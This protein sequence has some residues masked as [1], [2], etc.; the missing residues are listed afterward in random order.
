[1]NRRTQSLAAALVVALLGCPA[2]AAVSGLTLHVSP[3]GSDAGDGSAAKPFATPARA[4]QEVRK[5]AAGGLKQPVTVLLGAGTYELAQPLTFTPADGGSEA[6]GVTYA[7]APSQ[8]AILSGGRRIAGWKDVGGGLWQAQ[9]PGVKEGKWHF[10]QLW[11]NG[12][13]AVR[14]RTPNADTMLPPPPSAC[15]QLKDASLAG[16]LSSH[17]YTFPPGLLKE[18]K[19]LSDVEAVVLGNWETTRKRFDKVDPAAGVAQMAGPHAKPHDAIAAKPGRWFYLENAAEFLDAP[20]EWYLDRSSGIVSYRP[21]P[22]EDMTRAEAVAPRLTQVIVAAGTPDQP[23]RNLHLRGLEIAHTDWAPPPGGYLGIQACHFSGKTGWDKSKWNRVECAVRLDYAEGCSIRDCVL[24][25]LGG[26]GVELVTRCNRNI[27]AGNT[28]AD[29]SGNGIMLGGPRS[30][31]DVPKDN[32]IVGNVVH[33]CGVDYQGCIGIW[34][35]FAQRAVIA[36]NHV[37]TLPYGGISVGWQWNPAPTPAR[38]NIIE[39]NRI[40]DVMLVLA[41]SGGIYTLGFQPDSIIR[42]NYIHAVRRSPLSQG[43]PNNG[44]FLDEGTT[45]FTIEGNVLVD[46]VQAPLRFH[47]ATTNHVRGNWILLP[48]GR[49]HIEYNSTDSKN[50]HQ[51]DNNLLHPPADLPQAARAVIDQAGPPRPR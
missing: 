47:R 3:S 6:H 2:W 18:W 24:A 4:Q 49:P 34:A 35:G 39:N 23:L 50:I 42:G 14:A 16:D 21:R 31:A 46:I 40:H 26:G 37:Y 48:K 32:R 9:A 27:L 12:R 1:M 43:A 11:I 51:A 38:Q 8:R 41:D 15:L 33:D 5:L 28:V 44:M 19:N 29:V 7:A 10:R 17:T 36:H 45:G 20:G 30:E 22:G 25:H 13:R